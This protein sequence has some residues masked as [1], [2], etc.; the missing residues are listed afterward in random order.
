MKIKLIVFTLLLLAISCAKEEGEG[1]KNSIKGYVF[2]QEISRAT[3]QIISEYPAFEDALYI[4]YGSNAYYADKFILNYD[5]FYTFENLNKGKYTIFIYSD[6][7]LCNGGKEPIFK[8]IELLEK[9]EDFAVD[10]IY[11]VK[12][13]E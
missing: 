11:K 3:N 1:G 13:V 9:R 2:T 6:C 4:I 12:Y 8:D 5:G 7:N 10:T